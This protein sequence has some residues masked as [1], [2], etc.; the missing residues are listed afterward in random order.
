VGRADAPT[1]NVWQT[2]TDTTT[3]QI[4]SMTQNAI[5]GVPICGG[6]V[7]AHGMCQPGGSSTIVYISA[8]LVPSVPKTVAGMIAY[9]RAHES[10]VWRAPVPA[11]KL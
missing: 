8:R 6:K 7:A 5:P 10:K 9:S 4:L 11:P 1:D 3:G 2:R